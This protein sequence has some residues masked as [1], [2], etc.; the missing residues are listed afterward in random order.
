MVHCRKMPARWFSVFQ[1]SLKGY[2]FAITMRLETH[3]LSTHSANSLMFFLR[4][5]INFMGARRHGQEEHLPPSLPYGNV[6]VFLCISSYSKTPSRRI[7]Y[8]L[9]SHPVIGFLALRL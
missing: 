7:I 8:V 3:S 1:V 6:V 2:F 9:F 5:S 4:S